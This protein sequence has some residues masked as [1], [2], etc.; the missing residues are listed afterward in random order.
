MGPALSTPAPWLDQ[1]ADVLIL[2]RR[3]V[4]PGTSPERLSRFGDAVWHLAP[5]HPDA[6]KTVNAVHWTRWPTELVP[7]FKA[8]ALAALEHHRPATT[9]LGSEG[10]PMGV[11]TLSLK[12]RSLRV[13]AEWMHQ[14]TLTEICA[15]SDRQLDRYRSH[16]L[17]LEI[18]RGRQATLLAAVRTL[19]EYREHLPPQFRLDTADPWNGASGLRLAKAP[20]PGRENKTP[21]IAPATMEALLAWSL[22]MVED[23]G[24]DILSALRE[25][26]ML[27]ARTHPAQAPYLGLRPVEALRL[28]LENAVRDG[29]T[30]PGY[31]AHDGTHG[32]NWTHL[33]R[34]FG[35]G[36]V[37]NPRSRRLVHETGLPVSEDANLSVVTGVIDGR[38]WRNEPITLR[39]LPYLVRHL[40]A[41][42][43]VVTSY[44]SGMRPGEAL[45]LRRGCRRRDDATGQLFI[46]GRHGKG[47][48][49]TPRAVLG[50][51]AWSRSWV[52]VQPVHDAIAMLE[53][54]T[55]S[56]YLFPSSS[57]LPHTRRPANDHARVS[58]RMTA[59]VEKL[60]DWLNTTFVR[61]DGQPAVPPDPTRHIHPSR[62]RRTLARFIVRRPRGLIAAALQYAHVSTKVTLSYAGQ[63]DTGWM[64]DLAVERL[65]MIVEQ[66][67]HDWTL[68]QDGERVSGPSAPEYRKRIASAHRFAGRVVNRVRNVERFLAQ[69]D[70]SIHHGEGMTCVWRA[71]T[72]AC[73]NAKLAQ[74]LPA[75]DAPDEAE[76]QSAC[77]N[78]AYTDRD[79]IQLRERL[80]ALETGA[81]DVLSP[82]PLRDRAASQA[83]R[84]RRILD[85]HRATDQVTDATEEKTG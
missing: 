1:S 14:Q 48:G 84:V 46:D 61:S 30:L 72:A 54:L 70:P 56:L 24:P 21:R 20:A 49:R 63:A 18:S 83:A 51:D 82:R 73:R 31:R 32:V 38:P 43:F 4:R 23:I 8:F 7:G 9:V 37:T 69:V 53:A 64:E 34:L 59:D 41:A 67:E 26:R 78:L 79:I 47:R 57:V 45:N 80:A 19:W 71:E 42:C 81:A 17:A 52:V 13:L 74:G 29:R 77:Q 35:A 58:R 60:I 62:F 40:T 85:R 65:E 5:A 15:L 10:E 2:H 25:F 28:F 36:G 16:V 76:C 66:S 75:N 50:D 3:P 55:D 44:L 11:D 12:L 39:E 27:E 22:R 6:D 33:G 68:L